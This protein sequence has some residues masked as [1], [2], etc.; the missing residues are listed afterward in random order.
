MTD[1]P[2]RTWTPGDGPVLP[3]APDES[4]PA[5]ATPL[6]PGWLSSTIERARRADA[7]YRQ[8][9]SGKIPLS[10]AEVES[11]RAPTDSES[12]DAPHNPDVW[13]LRSRINRLLAYLG[14]DTS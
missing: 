14:E 11:L 4:Y 8:I 7:V 12:P 2:E 6:E 10:P 5:G 1:L 3:P 13:E 9:I